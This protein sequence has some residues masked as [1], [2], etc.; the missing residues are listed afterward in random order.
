MKQTFLTIY[1]IL[2]ALP[3]WGHTQRCHAV[4]KSQFGKAMNKHGYI[5]ERDRMDVMGKV[6][7]LNSTI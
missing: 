5:Q 1:L 2:F 4:Y 6:S 3:C 7:L